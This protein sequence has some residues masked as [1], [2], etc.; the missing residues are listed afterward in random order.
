MQSL[1]P[2]PTRLLAHAASGV[3]RIVVG[4][5]NPGLYAREVHGLFPDREAVSLQRIDGQLITPEMFVECCL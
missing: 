1:W 5:L 2:L 4:E 3:E